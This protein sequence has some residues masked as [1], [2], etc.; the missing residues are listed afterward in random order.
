MAAAQMFRNNASGPYTSCSTAVG[1]EKIPDAYRANFSSTAQAALAQYP[2]DWP[3]LEL[4]VEA[5]FSGYNLDYATADPADGHNYAT[6][7]AIMVAPLSRGN[8][9]I[10]SADSADLP[11]VNPAW[12]Q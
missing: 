8:V 2:A 11:V 4:S 5:G 6:I 7:V 3:E 10:A 12:L 1:W 9:T